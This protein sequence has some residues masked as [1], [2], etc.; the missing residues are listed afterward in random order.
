MSFTIAAVS[1]IWTHICHDI[2]VLIHLKHEFI[3][4]LTWAEVQTD[5]YFLV[6]VIPVPEVVVLPL[7]L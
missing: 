6:H 3:D 4:E 2:P 5:P 1:Q 7:R